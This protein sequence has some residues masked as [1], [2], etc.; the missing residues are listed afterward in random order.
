[1]ADHSILVEIGADISGLT[2]DLTRATNGIANFSRDIEGASAKITAIGKTV[3]GFGIAT[4]AGLGMAVNSAADFDTQLRKAGAIAG[5]TTSEFEAMKQSAIELGANTSKSASEVA[6]AMTELAAKGFDATSVIA[7]MPGIISAAEA[8]GED[9]ALTADTVSSALNIWGLEAAESSRVADVLAQSANTSAAG[10]GDLSYA[11]KYA[12]APAAALG[13][14]LE[15][16]SGAIGL[17]V[18][19]GLDGSSAGTALRAS[20]LALLNPSKENTELMKAM[21]VQITD[22][23]GNFVGLSS[24]V[25]NLSKSMEGQTDTQKAAT[26]AQLVGTEAVSGFLALMDAGPA[27]IDE[28]TTSLENSA[29]ASQEAAEKMKAGIGGAL[30][31][32]GGTIESIA[33]S[34][35]DQLVPAVTNVATWLSDML[36]RFMGLSEGMKQFLVVSATLVAGLF[37]I[38][39]PLL[40]IIGFIPN[41][42]GGM[43]ALGIAIKAVGSSM[44]FLLGPWGLVIAAIIAIGVALVTAYNNVEWFRDMVN[45]A[46]SYI[47][48]IF[49]GALSFISDVVKSVMGEVGRFFGE[50]LAEIRAFWDKNGAEITNLVKNYFSAIGETLKMYMGIF[51]GIFEAVWPILASIVKVAWAAIQTA[52]SNALALIKGV[53]NVALSIIR[54]DWSG[55]W[56]AIKDTAKEIM[57]NIIKYFGGIDL[58]SIGKDIIQGLINGIGSMVGAVTT[59]VKNIAKLVPEGLKKMLDIHSPSKLTFELGAFTGEG[60]GDGILDSVNGIVKAVKSISGVTAGVFKGIDA[61]PIGAKDK[62]TT[63]IAKKV[64]AILLTNKERVSII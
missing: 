50:K 52:I 25:D 34:I 24:L 58:K 6:V 2:R 30:E 14:S 64:I 8:S 33:I 10:V 55:A 43:Q 63:K 53:I 1:M 35:G 32:L 18:D 49:S 60:F 62:K 12:G 38:G 7:A 46:F 3:T 22:A 21:G 41:I 61:Q 23:Q 13:I 39:G 47:K 5:A 28:M 42:I 27:K 19:S 54:G 4:A 26:L 45:S 36:N 37:L 56:S 16:L 57:G 20:L 11:L 31:E 17:M 44:S 51:K 48:D 59:A 40:M 9:L 29:G 15:E